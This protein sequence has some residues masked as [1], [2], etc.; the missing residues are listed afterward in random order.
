MTPQADDKSGGGGELAEAE[1]KLALT[2]AEHAQLPARLEALAF[3]F[4]GEETLTDYYLEYARSPYGGSWDFTRLRRRDGARYLLTKK[5]WASGTGAQPVR[6]EDETAVDADTAGK[7]LDA[8]TAPPTLTKR[9]QTYKGRIA[10]R[11]ASIALD[12]L[13]LGDATRYFLECEVMT[14]AEDAAAVRETLKAWVR[15][16]LCIA[17]TEEAPSMLD[18]LLRHAAG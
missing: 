5:R 2:A 13:Q 9:R 10:D 7:M 3:R 1:I 11:D 12:Q 4:D 6:L 17:A 14:S 18:Q 16:Q 15:A 8:A